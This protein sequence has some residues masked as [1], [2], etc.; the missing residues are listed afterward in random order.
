MQTRRRL[1]PAIGTVAVT[2]SLRLLAIGCGLW[3]CMVGPD[4]DEQ[5]EDDSAECAS[6]ACGGPFE[7]AAVGTT[8]YSHGDTTSGWD[9]YDTSPAGSSLS[10]VSDPDRG[11]VIQSVS[12]GP[13]NGFRLRRT[14]LQPWGNTTQFNMEWWQKFS[15]PFVIYVSVNTSGGQ[16]YLMYTARDTDDLGSARYIHHGLGSRASDGTWRQFKRDLQ[17][18]LKDGQPDLTLLS[19]NAFL[20]RG[21]GKLDDIGLSAS[22][23]RGIWQTVAD[24]PTARFNL[25]A[26]AGKDGR[27]YAIGGGADAVLNTVEAYT[28]STNRWTT[29]ASMP[30]KRGGL[31]AVTGLDGRIYAIGGSDHLG[32]SYNNVEIYT[33]STNTWTTAA[34]APHGSKVAVV[35]SDGDIYALG[36]GGDQRT[37]DIYTPATNTWVTATVMP[38]VRRSFAAVAGPDGRIYVIG[39]INAPDA[40]ILNANDIAIVDVYSPR[41]NTWTTVADLPAPRRNMRAVVGSDGRI[42]AL[43][44]DDR[45]GQYVAV[46]VYTPTT[47]TWSVGEPMQRYLAPGRIQF[48]VAEASGRIYAIGGLRHSPDSGLV[49]LEGGESFTP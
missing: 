19:V 26:A 32:H 13:H 27:I 14:N 31:S 49:T 20:V 37:V 12:D 47:N 44:G 18:D 5:P 7:Q 28:P 24:M 21:S 29:V 38:R 3:G 9:T 2:R 46:Q 16:R 33:P 45:S 43:A 39:G 17:A 10:A 4:E 36:G 1:K 8:Y 41:T 35:G 42:Y 34:S 30:T 22:T 25:A 11:S 6:D 40:G 48:A 15:T 23:S